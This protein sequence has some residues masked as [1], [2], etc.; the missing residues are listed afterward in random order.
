MVEIAMVVEE[1]VATRAVH[2]EMNWNKEPG[3]L[4]QSTRTNIR[5]MGVV[6]LKVES[7][8]GGDV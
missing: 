1:E 3:S 6:L 8:V 2:E 5:V 7:D 4:E